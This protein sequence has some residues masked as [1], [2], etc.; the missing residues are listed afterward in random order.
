MGTYNRNLQRTDGGGYYFGTGALGDVTY[1]SGTVAIESGNNQDSQV[2]VSNYKSITTTNQVGLVGRRRAWVVY[3]QENFSP[4]ANFRNRDGGATA[5]P[6]VDQFVTHMFLPLTTSNEVQHSVPYSYLN[7]PSIPAV[8]GAGAVGISANGIG[9]TGTAGTNGGM[10]GGGSG[11]RQAA[12]TSGA[13]SIATCWAGGSS[14]GGAGNA[15]GVSATGFGGAGGAGGVS[16]DYAAGGGTGNPGGAGINGGGD[17]STGLAGILLIIVGG[18]L[19]NTSNI[20]TTGSIGGGA[21][22]GGTTGRVGGAGGGGG[23][24]IVLYKTLGALGNIFAN[25]SSANTVS[26]GTVNRNGGSGGSGTV[27]AQQIY[28]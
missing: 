13:G 16:G 11:A 28:Y 14:G 27:T 2:L 3:I 18:T 4:G 25:G 9:G 7:I 1:S 26:G 17:G 6:T 19:T 24:T 5:T 20:Q 12:G 8:G 21:T 23:R 22:S 10:G 15:S